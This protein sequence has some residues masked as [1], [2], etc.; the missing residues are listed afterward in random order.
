MTHP[1]G[2]PVDFRFLGIWRIRRAR[3]RA[4]ALRR[5]FRLMGIEHEKG[6]AEDRRA[7]FITSCLPTTCNDSGGWTRTNNIP[8]N[9][10]LAHR[11]KTAF[12]PETTAYYCVFLP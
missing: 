3:F 6:P 5:G 1:I 11:L 8:I 10:G 7:F 2:R 12:P 4:S 9:R